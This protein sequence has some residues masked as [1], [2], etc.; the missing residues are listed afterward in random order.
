MAGVCDIISAGD[1]DGFKVKLT[2]LKPFLSAMLW[3]FVCAKQGYGDMPI[4]MKTNRI[5]KDRDFNILLLLD[6][7][8]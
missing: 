8:R 3:P 4:Q 1:A 6:F 7:V 2:K 5:K